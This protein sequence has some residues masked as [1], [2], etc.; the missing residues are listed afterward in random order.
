MHSNCTEKILFSMKMQNHS[1][2]LISNIEQK[3]DLELM[4]LCLPRLS[5]I[6]H[7]S[8]QSV[9]RGFLDPPVS[10]PTH[11]FLTFTRREKP[12]HS[13]SRLQLYLPTPS[14]PT[15]HP[16]CLPL[17]VCLLIILLPAALSLSYKSIPTIIIYRVFLQQHL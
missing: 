17:L 6:H 11:Y 9:S 3:S 5:Q 2:A 8:L 1:T 10:L 14:L 13:P 7:T 15:E 16:Q 12:Q 4:L